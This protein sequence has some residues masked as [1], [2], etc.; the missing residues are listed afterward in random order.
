MPAHP[1]ITLHSFRTLDADPFHLEDESFLL[2]SSVRRTVNSGISER[3]VD[4]SGNCF[5]RVEADQRM[6]FSLSGA[7]LE[8]DGLADYYPGRNLSDKALAFAA[9]DTIQHQ[10]KDDGIFIYES[11]TDTDGQG[12]LRDIAIEIS[13]DLH[14]G[15]DET[16]SPPDVIENPGGGE[17]DATGFVDVPN[18]VPVDITD[19]AKSKML[20]VVFNGMELSSGVSKSQLYDNSALKVH[21]YNG[22]TLLDTYT[23]ATGDYWSRYNDASSGDGA[24][25]VIARLATHPSMDGNITI[26]DDLFP[27]ST[28]DNT[29]LVAGD[30]ILV[31]NQ[32]DPAENGIYVSGPGVEA[33]RHADF[34]ASD[35]SDFRY[36]ICDVSESTQAGTYRTRNPAGGT[37]ETTAITWEDTDYTVDISPNQVITFPATG[38]S[39]TVTKIVVQRYT[40]AVTDMVIATI[41]LDSSLT[42]PA[43]KIIR[44]PLDAIKLSMRYPYDGTLTTAPGWSAYGGTML[45]V[46]PA[47]V[48][49]GYI[50]GGNSDTHLGNDNEC[51][52]VTAY[53]EGSSNE[54]IPYATARIG[55]YAAQWTFSGN[56]VVQNDDFDVPDST[57]TA[58]ESTTISAVF[59]TPC[60]SSGLVLMK[61]P[62]SVPAISAGTTVVLP[63]SAPYGPVCD[64]DLDA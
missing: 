41:D 42:V 26:P 17:V 38:S 40:S 36:V 30:I 45:F 19:T 52:D 57:T 20:E 2:I 21:I 13:Y 8:V 22:A 1:A 49:G 54:L 16:A 4:T 28:I 62:S 10:F 61:V 24:T 44:I 23:N 46:P 25:P 29:S 47:A 60:N 39:R 37:L 31:K 32:T 55:R 50:L 27:G 35:L 5:L 12:V 64:L 63:E 43:N 3:R 9:G 6:Q 18:Q 58:V 14:G 34:D 51:L 7:V 53:I 59:V 33:S 56:T 15:L 11:A 48:W